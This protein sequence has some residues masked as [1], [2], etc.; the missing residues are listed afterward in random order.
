MGSGRLDSP[1][2]IVIFQPS[3]SWTSGSPAKLAVTEVHISPAAIPQLNKRP[4][5]SF[6]FRSPTTDFPPDRGGIVV[7]FHA[8]MTNRPLSNG[9]F[10]G[11]TRFRAS[12]AIMTA[13]GSGRD[14]VSEAV[15][16]VSGECRDDFSD[17]LSLP[18]LTELLSTGGVYRSIWEYSLA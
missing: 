7:V 14:L 16:D 5:M 9:E 3:K 13:G 4:F 12:V 15:V 6:P 1:G 8:K 18:V 2:R 17:S 10:P 11:R